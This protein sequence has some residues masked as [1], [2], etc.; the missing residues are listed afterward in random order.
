LQKRLKVDYDGETRGIR[1]IQF[2]KERKEYEILEKLDFDAKR[3]RM[4]VLARDPLR[5]EYVLFC[6]GADSAIF[7]KCRSGNVF[8]ENANIKWF[9]ESGWR[10][11]AIAYKTLTESEYEKCK[12]LLAD[13]NEDIL[14]K[15]ERIESVYELIE[16]D[17][18]LLGTTAIEDRL[19]ESVEQTLKSLRDAGIKIWVLTGD[20]F[21]TAIN[22]S[23]SCKH[24]SN[25]MN[26]LDLIELKSLEELKIRLENIEA[27]IV[28]KNKAQFG[29]MIDGETLKSIYENN[30]ESRLCNICLRCDAV[31]CCRLSPAQKAQL[32]KMIK[33]TKEKPITAAIGDGTN[34]VSMIQEANVGIGIYGKEGRNAA[35]SA[36]L[37]FAKFKHLRRVILTHGYTFYMRSAILVQYFFYKNISFVMCQVY[38]AFLNAF[39]VNVSC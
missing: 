7:K 33:E 13:A 2:P 21:E 1:S 26:K 37:A 15:Q 4:S 8:Q 23:Y 20:K 10:T 28:T 16:S 19:Q 36:D 29:L 25:A 32:V 24:F 18:T 27:Q 30:F 12:R 6:K 17:L 31:L 38:Y 3:K 39:S 34:D 35:R 11:L 22:I 5:K 9:A 14:N